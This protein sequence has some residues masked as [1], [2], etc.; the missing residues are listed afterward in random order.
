MVMMATQTITPMMEADVDTTG[1][2]LEA[3]VL[4]KAATFL[5]EVQ[6]QWQGDPSH[7]Q[8][9]EALRYNQRLWSLFQAE[10]VEGEDRLPVEVR[11]NIL[12]LSAFVDKRTFEIMAY[13]APEKLDIL[14]KIN[15]NL[16]EGLQ[17]R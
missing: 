10:M 12:S 3:S 1:R 8:L 5:E 15:R 4:N 7:G 6:G 13:P 2:E 16:A 14:I 11:Q 9:D 17:A